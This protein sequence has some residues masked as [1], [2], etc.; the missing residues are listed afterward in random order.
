MPRPKPPSPRSPRRAAARRD[1][2]RRQRERR[3][4]LP[5]RE[6]ARERHRDASC[7][8]P[9]CARSPA[10]GRSSRRS[11]RAARHRD[12]TALHV[13]PRRLRQP[14][15]QEAPD[16]LDQPG[17]VHRAGRRSP[18]QDAHV[19]AP[20]TP[21]ISD[22]PFCGKICVAD[23]DCPSGSGLQG[24]R[25]QV[26]QRE[27]R[28][29]RQRSAPSSRSRRRG[30]RPCPPVASDARRRRGRHPAVLPGISAA[31]RRSRGRG[32]RRLLARRKDK[33]SATR[34]RCSR[35]AVPAAAAAVHLC[36]ALPAAFR[37]AGNARLCK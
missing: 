31:S 32:A 3:L 36:V 19:H 30:R 33:A 11:P 28:R 15:G 17:L 34:A 7:V 23:V 14:D 8:R 4:A 12:R 24:P 18:A 10:S 2:R 5:R 25:E 21:L 9:T 13:L 37:S 20:E 35:S 29:R 22:A 27:A 1:S 26:R 6:E 16:G